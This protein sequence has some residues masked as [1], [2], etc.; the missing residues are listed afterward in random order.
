VDI[1]L[2]TLRDKRNLKESILGAEVRNRDSC[3]M[4]TIYNYSLT[5]LNFSKEMQDL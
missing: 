3:K 5:E 2:E 4:L 1:F